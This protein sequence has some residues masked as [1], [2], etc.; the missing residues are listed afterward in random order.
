MAR[1]A[2]AAKVA[3]TTIAQGGVKLSFL[4]HVD[5]VINSV[6]TTT[7]NTDVATLVADGATPTQ[8]HV[9]TLNTDWT[10]LKAGTAIVPPTTDIIISYDITAV[11]SFN[12]LK[13][14]VALL[15]EKIR[16]TGD[17]SDSK[18]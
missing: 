15:L 4:G 3:S 7:V 10:A 11:G 13:Q 12:V 18:Y 16:L 1:R 6:A 9:N 2:V 14:A 5:D 17:L 8:A